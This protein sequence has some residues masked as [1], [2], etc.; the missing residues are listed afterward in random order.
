[1]GAVNYITTVIRFRAPGMTWFRMPATVWAFAHP[2]LNAL[3]VPVLGSVGLML[4]A[5]RHFERNSS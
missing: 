5:D 2:I 1:M 3:F 4:L